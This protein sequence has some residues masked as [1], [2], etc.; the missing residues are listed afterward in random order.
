MSFDLEAE[1]KDLAARRDIETAL[2]R[3]MRAQDRL[4]PDLHL[5]A[6]HE[7][8]Y[9]DCGL[10]AGM[11]A[12]FVSFAQGLLGDLESSQH[13]LGQI[14]I[15]IDGDRASGEVYFFAQHRVMEDDGPKDLFVAGRYIDEYACRSGQWRILKRKE[16][17][18]WA[19]TDPASDESFLG[20]NPGLPL[21]GRGQD[22]FSC[23][24]DWPEV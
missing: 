21:G 20:P 23:R 4:L 6:F 5:S 3:Y 15:E 17:I 13:M 19:R 12:E 7:D 14:D 9:V 24:R 10:M 11:A 2:K 1:V 22:D 16:L 8:A 18:D